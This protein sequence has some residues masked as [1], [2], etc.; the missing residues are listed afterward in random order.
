MLPARTVREEVRWFERCAHG[1]D[2]C[3]YC[4]I[5]ADLTTKAQQMFEPVEPE[6]GKDG[7]YVPDAR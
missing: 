2:L 5:C 1:K 4:P 6:K 3:E 7:T